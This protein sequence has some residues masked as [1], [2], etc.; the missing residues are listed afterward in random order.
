[1]FM[2]K[3]SERIKKIKN[4]LRMQPKSSTVSEI[5]EALSKR[6]HLA[7]SRKTIERDII[8]MA[9]NNNVQVISGTP[10]RYLLCMPT[11]IEVCLKVE[12][13][14]VILNH[15]ESRSELYQKLNKFL[16]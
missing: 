5:H 12:E 10:A 16:E 6:M 7:V 15:L 2:T 14:R 3:K 4:F 8:E 13:I 9:D 11:E 1:M